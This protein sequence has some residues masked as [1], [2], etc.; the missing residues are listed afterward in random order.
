MTTLLRTIVVAAVLASAHTVW[1]QRDA[2]SK[3]SGSVYEAP[4]FYGSAGAYQDNAYSHVQVLQDS[5]SYGQPVPPAVVKEHAAAVRNNLTESQK[6]YARLRESLK[7]NKTAAKHLDEID[8][9]HK[10]ALTHADDLEAHGSKGHGDSAKVHESSKALS[11]S[12]KSAKAAHGK[13]M[14]HAKPKARAETKK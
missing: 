12:L 9:H 13:L 2:V 5:A 7:D 14:E 11:E 6:H 10:K 8:Q 3:I 1:A 4:Y